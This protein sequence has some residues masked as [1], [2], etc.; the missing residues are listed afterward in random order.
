MRKFSRSLLW[1]GLVVAGVAACGDDVTIT[2]PPPPPPPPP[3]TV[4][5]IS[6]APSGVTLTHPATQQMT[7]AVNA[8]AGVATTVTWS[9]APGTVATIS[10]TGLLTTV[11][12]GNVA[13]QA[14]ST[15]VTS[16]CGV[17]TIT[18]S[19]A[20]APT[21]TQVLVTPA[22]PTVVRPATGSTT[23]QLSAAVVGTN[24]PSQ[25]VTWSVATGGLG[26]T[27]TV[28][29]TGLVTVTSAA[30]AG[31]V[32][33]QAC[34]TVA[35]FT[36][37]CGTSAIIIQIPQPATVSIQS[38]T[39]VPQTPGT[40]AVI[41]ASVPQPV[42]LTNVNCQIEVTANVNAGDQQLGRLD[43]L[44]GGQVVASQT[45]PGT[46]A[47]NAEE[48]AI[49]APVDITLNVNTRQLK[50]G[51]PAIRKRPVIFNGNQSV[52]ANLY[53]VG[54]STPLASNAVPVVMNNLDVVYARPGV[55]IFT[56]TSSLQPSAATP[57]V[58]VGA[59]TWFATTQTASTDFI[60]YSN[61]LPTAFTHSASTVC[62]APTA[63]ATIG[64]TPST[65][66]TLTSTFSCAGFEG[67]NFLGA[68]PASALSYAPAVTGPDG[69][70]LASAGAGCGTATGLCYTDVGS[71]YQVPTGPLAAP[72]P[73]NRYNPIMLSVI[74]SSFVD[75]EGPSVDIASSTTLV[76][77][78]VVAANSLF[79]QWW[80]SG[81]AAGPPI[82]ASFVWGL[83]V[84][85]SS[86]TADPG[87]VFSPGCGT[88]GYVAAADGGV[89]LAAGFPTIRTTAIAAPGVGAGL[90]ESCTGTTVAGRD[91]ANLAV[92]TTSN[93]NAIAGGGHRVC[94]YAEDLLANASSTVLAVST[95]G[96]TSNGTNKS[97][98][99][100]VDK[101]AASARLAGSTAAVPAFAPGTH[102]PAIG[103]NNT[104]FNITSGLPTTAWG[105]EGQDDRAGFDQAILVALRPA[106][107]TI[108]RYNVAAPT[109]STAACAAGFAPPSLPTLL[110]D[111]W[112]RAVGTNNVHCGTGGTLAAAGIYEYL[113]RT[114]DRANNQSN[115][116]GPWAYW[117][118]LTAPS[119]TGLGFPTNVINPGA[120][121][122][123]FSISANDNQSVNDGILQ[124]NYG[125]GNFPTSGQTGVA[126]TFYSPATAG[127]LPVV[128]STW[129]QDKWDRTFTSVVNGGPFTLGYYIGRYDE[130]CTGVA[131]TPYASCAAGP[132]GTLPAALGDYLSG[133]AWQ[134]G[135]AACNAGGCTVNA[136]VRD[137][138]FNPNTSGPGITV[139]MLTT[140]ST[141]AGAASTFWGPTN[142]ISWTAS[143]SGST[144]TANH[145]T[146]SSLT[147]PYFDDVRLFRAGTAA[148]YVGIWMDCGVVTPG[149][150]GVLVFDN[151]IQRVWRWTFLIPAVNTGGNVCVG[152]AAQGNL[153]AGGAWRVVGTK[154]GAALM[155]PSF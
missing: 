123:V 23:I 50:D 150:S 143:I 31:T 153:A 42:V 99:F 145:T 51:T 130:T 65:G 39:W 119:V 140:Q 90:V 12:A 57:A 73:E 131:A 48:A 6:V 53:V 84:P 128:G 75:R 58:T 33:V 37:V 28:S 69:T 56:N 13:V 141:A 105:I 32:N 71:A 2:P 86:K 113:G 103:N 116:L 20:P 136:N 61:T 100:G 3:P 134:P 89:G 91:A 62:G 107:Q 147:L 112:V 133:A 127:T 10:A 142:T 78:R 16:V 76:P 74:P 111:G 152:T 98:A 36:N 137:A 8:D 77:A 87:G 4:H 17:A 109:G 146:P 125:A 47:P 43:I 94:T 7:A 14:C 40:C 102:S 106:D 115:N 52:I 149:A 72:A 117:V 11:G 59:N 44:I 83:C 151:G 96:L 108:T 49:S 81:G 85:A 129:D 82:T 34:S 26:A 135:N 139:P 9:A 27:V 88:S 38:I 148:P 21:V 67:Q 80:V 55:G 64:G 41:P 104:I 70:V 22:N 15:V 138:A 63:A 30:A 95:L 19:T 114:W 97:N 45:F 60:A 5:S 68:A 155:T 1:T 126:Y 124:F 18:V 79:D 110:S 66:I 144:V 154:S 29:A 25:N 93:T 54:A 46:V 24:N 122:Y 120:G 101:L 121:S 132:A 118:D 92:T 35:G